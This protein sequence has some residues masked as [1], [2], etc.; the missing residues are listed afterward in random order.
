M[1]KKF[2]NKYRNESTRLQNWNYGWN[3]TYFITICTKNKA[4]YFGEIENKKMILSQIGELANKF[5]FTI[6]DHFSF[7]KLGN[8]VVMPNHTHG[9]L[10]V[11]KSNE[12]GMNGNGM[13][14]TGMDGNGMDETGM[15][16]N[17]M[18]ETGMDGNGM[19]ETGTDGNGTD[20]TGTDE[21]GTDET[22]TNG[23]GMDG[24]GTNATRGRENG[25]RENGG[26]ENGDRENVGTRHCLVPTFS[27]SKH[28]TFLPRQTPASLDAERHASLDAERHASPDAERHASPDAERH[29]PS[30]MF[31][32]PEPPAFLP[33]KPPAFFDA[34]SNAKKT[35]GQSR[36]Q[37]QGKNTISSIIGSYKS[38]VTKNA[39][40]SNPDFAW[41]IR[42][43]DHIVRN[44]KSFENIQNYIATNPENWGNDKFF[45]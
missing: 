26:R 19:D 9:I 7:V 22:G 42:F 17:G 27:P 6:P 11:N 36:F 14:E 44:A 21:T 39:R 5:W 18:D 3:G 33:A 31:P 4:P 41:Q 2:K 35:I 40:Y 37:N 29:A 28:P 34:E 25:D 13:D 12:T 23:N 15:D 43:H 45:Q 24:T 10:I 16:G 30:P 1:S 20:E 32:D 8:F 38:I